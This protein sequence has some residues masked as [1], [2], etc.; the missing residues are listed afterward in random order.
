MTVLRQ[1][2]I[3]AVMGNL[4]LGI[5]NALDQSILGQSHVM[6]SQV[7]PGASLV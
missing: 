3:S 6:V 4:R 2:C 7:K 5:L 1:D